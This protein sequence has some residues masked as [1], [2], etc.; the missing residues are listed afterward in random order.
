[1]RRLLEDAVAFYRHNLLN[2]PAGESALEYLRQKRNLTDQTM[3]VF[4]IGY[5]PKSWDASMQHFLN[6]GYQVK[7][8]IEVGLVTQ[9]DDGAVYD[10]FRHRVMFPIRD[11]RGRMVGF[12][13]RILDPEDIPKFLNS[14]QTALFDKSRTLYGMDL[15][16]KAIRSLDQSVIVE[17]YLDVIAL[18]QAGFENTV[19]PMGTAL[20]EYQLRQLKRFSRN[21]V[22]ALDPDAAGDKATLRG[23][24]VARQAMDREQEPVFDARGLLGHESRLQADIRVSTLPDGLDPDEIVHRDPDEWRGIIK[25]ARP[26]VIHVME[27]LAANVDLEDPKAKDYI[28]NQVLPLIQDVPSAIER[29]TYRQR[30][31]RLLKVDERTLLDRRLATRQRQV[32]IRRRRTHLPTEAPPKKQKSSAS[33][34]NYLMEAHCL[35]VL[36]RMPDLIYKIDR[37]LQESELSRLTA[38]DFQH[39]DHQSIFLILQKSLDQDLEDPL[40]FML[41]NLSLPLMDL[42]DELLARSENLDSNE[43]KVL[44]DLLRS[45]LEMRRHD[46]LQ[47]I[48]YIRFQMEETQ[49]NGDVKA[50]KHLQ[51]M[52]E[53]SRSLNT[54]NEALGKFTGDSRLISRRNELRRSR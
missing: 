40:T 43:E 27:T 34:G 4:G 52:A 9:R 48:E 39:A 18:H 41:N 32:T 42:T 3:E 47:R 2:T 44:N 53:Y 51:T 6:K 35:G 49:E 31:A 8:L 26:I 25:E 16:R 20:T 30:L 38:N 50:T 17:G 33:N 11:M 28:A 14:P 54:I 24:Q 5:A 46:L 22:L 7:D 1:M 19:S 36:I 37:S 15:A 45:I 12:G 29:D 21:I 23:L 13:A 10:R